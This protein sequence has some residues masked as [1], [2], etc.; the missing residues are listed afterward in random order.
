VPIRL[1]NTSPSDLV[2]PCRFPCPPIGMVVSAGSTARGFL[3]S[4][5][6]TP[7]LINPAGALQFIWTSV[8]PSGHSEEV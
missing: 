3:P 5:S 4:R 7:Y 1:N 8:R 2:K 6:D